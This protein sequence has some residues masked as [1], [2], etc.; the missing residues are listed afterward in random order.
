[1]KKTLIASAIAAA[2]ISGTA[3]AQESN[4]PTV[5][6]NIQYAL[7]HN[8]VDGGG[9]D[10]AHNDNGSTIGFTHEHAINP[11]LTGF[12]KIEL[13]GID[14]DDKSKGR[15]RI[16][17]DEAYIGVKGD[18]FGQLWVG[19]DDS[20]YETTIDKIV[21]Y[22]EVATL[23]IGGNYTTGEGDLIQYMTP[24]FG[25]LKL[26]AAVQI[27]GDGDTQSGGKSYPYQLAAIYS[28]DALTLAFAMDSNDGDTEYSSGGVEAPKNNEN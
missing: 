24:S 22:Y 26:G 20:L 23:N 21:N 6:G 5:Y 7:T 17:L 8:N 13:D 14:A 10:I 25:G 9:S 11:S 19:S 12:M 15:G 1:M 2:T 28:V 16:K 18:N 4:L 3:L 27:N